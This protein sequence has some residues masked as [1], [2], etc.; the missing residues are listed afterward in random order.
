MEIVEIMSFQSEAK[1][2]EVTPMFMGFPEMSETEHRSSIKSS[3]ES[4]FNY[5][6]PMD[7][8]RFQ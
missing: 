7:Q 2:I 8:Q 3:S 4:K 6:V 1:R 5:Y